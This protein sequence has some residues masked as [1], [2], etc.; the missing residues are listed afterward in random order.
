MRGSFEDKDGNILAEATGLWLM[1]ERNIGRWTTEDEQARK[2][3]EAAERAK[4][5]L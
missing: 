1:V 2:K 4:A 3:K 5:K